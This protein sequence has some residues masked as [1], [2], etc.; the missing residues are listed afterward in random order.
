MSEKPVQDHYRLM[1]EALQKLEKDRGIL[2]G[3]AFKKWH[4]S[5]VGSYMIVP[6]IIVVFYI[7]LG[8]REDGTTPFAVFWL[9]FF[10]VMLNSTGFQADI[11]NKRIDKIVELIEAEK[12]LEERCQASISFLV[13]LEPKKKPENSNAD[14]HE[15]D[16]SLD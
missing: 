2:T 13:S 5:S 3:S 1:Q 10:P 6:F 4:S 14:S 16:H 7:I 9:L 11:V 15:S 8:I 12:K